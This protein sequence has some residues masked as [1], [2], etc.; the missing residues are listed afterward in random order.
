VYV[1]VEDRGTVFFVDG[2]SGGKIQ[3]TGS[4]LNGK[5][6]FSVACSTSHGGAI[7]TCIIT[8]AVGD[9]WRPVQSKRTAFCARY[10]DLRPR[11]KERLGREA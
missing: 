3:A 9:V 1:V 6:P 10:A 7:E 2:N 11:K 8:N 5:A 4:P